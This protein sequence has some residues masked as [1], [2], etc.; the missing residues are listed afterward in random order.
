MISLFVCPYF[1]EENFIILGGALIGGLLPDIDLTTSFLGSRVRPL[2]DL[3]SYFFAHRTLTHSLPFTLILCAVISRLNRFFS[4][5]LMVGILSHIYLDLVPKKGTGVAF[6]YPFYK[7]RI[8]IWKK[9]CHNR[10]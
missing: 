6:L 4:F 9:K 5:G 8:N 2:S 7:K 3:I 10:I 1:S